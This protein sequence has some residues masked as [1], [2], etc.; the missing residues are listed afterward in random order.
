MRMI[1][2]E[3]TFGRGME[4]RQKGLLCRKSCVKGEA[5]PWLIYQT[6]WK[7]LT[8]RSKTH[9]VSLNKVRQR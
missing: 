9:L 1:R 3:M 2:W 7:R 6:S 4:G 8:I 5:C